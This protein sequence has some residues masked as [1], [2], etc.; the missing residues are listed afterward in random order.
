MRLTYA[1]MA[2]LAN[3]IIVTKATMPV[4]MLPLS[5]LDTDAV[6]VTFSPVSICCVVV[7][8]TKVVI[9]FVIVVVTS[10]VVAD[11]VV[12]GNVEVVEEAEEVVPS[13]VLESELGS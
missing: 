9:L 2:M 12:V 6:A 11:S 4:G 1:R 8:G 13:V 10:I 3:V 5:S 7:G